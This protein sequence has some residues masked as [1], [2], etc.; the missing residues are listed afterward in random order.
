MKWTTEETA[1]LVRMYA[2]ARNSHL[3]KQL[4]RS[5]CA[6]RTKAI[7][8]GLH[9]A[10]KQPIS[11]WTPAMDLWL[12]NIYPNNT[13]NDCAETLQ[14][15]ESAVSNRANKL[16]LKKAPDFKNSGQF[17]KGQQPPNKG[18]KM[19]SDLYARCQ[20]TMFKKGQRSAN[21]RPV[22]S[23]RV[24]VY[25]YIEIKIADPG[26]WALEHRIVWEKAYGKIPTGANIQFKDG[27]SQNTKLDNL[28]LIFRN[29]QILENT[30]QRYPEEL[31]KSI[32]L[33]SKLRKTAKKYEQQN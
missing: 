32:R 23:K 28:Y 1:Y 9:K 29:E 11:V 31:Q 15:S 13:N 24:N 27:N 18:K 33:V 14:V 30:I 5:I 16:G 20:P 8:L 19:P 2:K 6:I 7:T 25:G 22:G 10:R 3:A 21:Y 4:N 17:K 26:K 12:T